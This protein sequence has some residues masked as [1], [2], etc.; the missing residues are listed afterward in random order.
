MIIGASAAYGI[1]S[2]DFHSYGATEGVCYPYGGATVTSKYIPNTEVTAAAI[3][4][5][6]RVGAGGAD[7]GY[8]YP[9]NA[10]DEIEGKGMFKSKLPIRLIAHLYVSCFHL[11]R[12]D[13]SPIRS[14]ADLRGKKVSLGAPKSGTKHVSVLVPEAFGIEHQ[15][16]IKRDRLTVVESAAALKGGKVDTF[17][18]AGGFR[19]LPSLTSQQPQDLQCALSPRAR[20][21][22]IFSKSTVRFT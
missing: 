21:Y 19:L 16:D 17:F 12:A 3:D 7:L 8:A 10:L 6:K 22:L 2:A 11:V 20:P 14:V 13:G 5:L 15:K 9:D 18:W 1:K 4:N